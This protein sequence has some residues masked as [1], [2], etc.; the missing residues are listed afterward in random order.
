MLP[1]I[2][3]PPAPPAAAEPLDTSED[4]AP[5]RLQRWGGLLLKVGIT[6]LSL[7]WTWRLLAGMDWR[8]LSLRLAQ[9]N[10]GWLIAA[11]VFLLMRWS[12]WDGRFRAAARRG[13]GARHPRPSAS[14]SS[15]RPP[16]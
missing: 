16:P 13:G 15:W 11:G 3:D 2:E 5:E 9:A 6:V 7:Y 10:G 8:E 1:E 12:A 4:S 14:S